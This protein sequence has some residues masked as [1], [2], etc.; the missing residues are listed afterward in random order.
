MLPI[1]Q[2]TQGTREEEE[3]TPRAPAGDTALKTAPV[4]II[5]I[6]PS[7]RK[8]GQQ[9]GPP[10]LITPR[11]PPVLR[12]EP[13]MLTVPSWRKIGSVYRMSRP[14]SKDACSQQNN[15]VSGEGAREEVR[16]E[17]AKVQGSIDQGCPGFRKTTLEK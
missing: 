12:L 13:S 8:N 10:C 17:A 2:E 11:F 3:I 6:T 14:P 4:T 15:P 5:V 16:P 9:P 7:Q 1:T